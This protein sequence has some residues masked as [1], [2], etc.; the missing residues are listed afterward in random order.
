LYRA[1][2]TPPPAMLQGLDALVYALQDTGVR[3]YTFIS[4]MG[5]AMEA[6]AEAG[7]E[8]LVLDRPN[9]LGAERVQGP[10]V[11]DRFPSFVGQWNIPYAYGMTCGE[12]ARMIN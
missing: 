12:L 9:P 1:T 8:F 6:C 11:E 7:V 10:M 3:S 5:L 2:P 4:T